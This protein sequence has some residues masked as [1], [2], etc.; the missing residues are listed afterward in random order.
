MNFT[1]MFFIKFLQSRSG[2][3]LA[4]W[5]GGS[6]QMTPQTTPQHTPKSTPQHGPM[7]TGQGSANATSDPFADFGK[8]RMY[9]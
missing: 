8:L 5:G 4:G 2:P 3:N 1:F 7:G 6:P 9:R